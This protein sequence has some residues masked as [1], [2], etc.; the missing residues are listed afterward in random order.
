MFK[1]WEHQ[2]ECDEMAKENLERFESVK[3]WLKS[4][5]AN[6]RKGGLTP[7]AHGI[8][9]ETMAD[10]LTFVRSGPDRG[11]NPDDLLEEARRDLEAAKERLSD[12]F[13]WLKG[14]RVKG[15][16]ARGV[17]ISHNSAL[18]K[19]GFMRG[20][21][22]HNAVGFG[23][24]KMPRRLVSEVSKA[25]E[26]TPIYDY[27]EETE[28]NVFRNDVLQHFAGNLSFRD[29]TIALG[30]LSTGAD[31]AD[32]LK[33]NVGFVR[34]QEKERRLFWRG[35]RE[36]DLE[37]FKVF[38]SEEATRFMRKYAEQERGG[39]KD[40]E[41]LF[42]GGGYSYERKNPQTKKREKVMVG[43]RLAQHAL[44]MNFK[45]AAERMGFKNDE[46]N[47]FRPKRFR[48]LFRT[49][50]G[51]AGIDPG[52]INAFMG[53]ST[54]VSGSYL[55]KPR[56]LFVKEYI[57]VEPFVTGFGKAGETRQF[58]QR[59]SLLEEEVEKLRQEV[60][61]ARLVSEEMIDKLVVEPGSG[62]ERILN[63]AEVLARLARRA[64]RESGK[65]LTKAD[66][67]RIISEAFRR[68]T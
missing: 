41:P 34:G 59:I 37:E 38:F 8:R 20:F 29:Q 1:Y 63:F 45:H 10:F 23:K 2:K 42:I 18:T 9:L 32:L 16:K 65:K 26:Q 14:E 12:Y 21:F 67:I 53:H 62:E 61:N 68:S 33:L 46:R 35:N 40:N 11:M 48:H 52:F 50:C 31:A 57:K 54:D 49:A 17:K 55:E 4:A 7:N 51:M 47:P 24:W 22:S 43:D 25:D 64:E 58:A 66:V 44:A 3:S 36:K 60:K 28:R 6:S 30:L 15:Y 5:G 19:L 39:A 56:G 27:E 13:R